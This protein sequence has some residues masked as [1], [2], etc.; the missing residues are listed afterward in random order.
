MSSTNLQWIRIGND[1][2]GSVRNNGVVRRFS[3]VRKCGSVVVNANE[4]LVSIV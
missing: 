2:S 4:I 3:M 1:E